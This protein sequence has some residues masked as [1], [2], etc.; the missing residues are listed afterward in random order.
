MA[1]PTTATEEP[2]FDPSLKKRRKK[3]VNFDED[4]LGADGA[5][6]P[7]TP[8]VPPAPESVPTASILKDTPAPA[9][10]PAPVPA[11]A[12]AAEEKEE[13]LNAMFGDLKKKKKKKEIPLDLELVRPSLFIAAPH[14]LFNEIYG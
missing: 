1:D 3:K 12:P 11:P 10:T 4:P 7:E 13:D 9:P 8:A 5:A 14:A 2:L 6:E